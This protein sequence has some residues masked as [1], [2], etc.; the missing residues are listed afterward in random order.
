MMR[1]VFEKSSHRESSPGSNVIFEVSR[2]F[3]P[4]RRCQ[5]SAKLTGVC[6]PSASG[7]RK[8][9]PF[10]FRRLSPLL[11]PLSPSLLNP[12]GLPVLSERDQCSFHPRPPASAYTSRPDPLARKTVSL[13]KEGGV[14][15]GLEVSFSSLF[16]FFHVENFFKSPTDPRNPKCWISPSP[17][18]R[19]VLNFPT[20]PMTRMFPYSRFF[21]SPSVDR[22]IA[23]SFRKSSSPPEFLGAPS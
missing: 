21:I 7:S 10:L 17:L 12:C 11:P 8:L 2:V 16:F 22:V 18:R 23:P 3:D 20:S 1:L 14:M 13:P 6:L 19:R 4:T 15:F 9:F 5:I